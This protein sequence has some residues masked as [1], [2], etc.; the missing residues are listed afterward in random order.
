MKHHLLLAASMAIVLI[1]APGESALGQSGAKVP[2]PDPAE[3]WDAVVRDHVRPGRIDGFD[4]NV[5]DYAAI[6]SDARWPGVLRAFA[7]AAEPRPTKERMAFWINAYNVM[8]IHVV[9]ENYPV[10]SIRDVGSWLRPVWKRDAGVVAGQMRTLDEIE[11][12][13]LRSMGD[14]R[15]HAAV[16]C[17]SV[18]CPPLR[19][20]AYTGEDLD[21]Q[22]DHQMRR[23]L[24][25]PEIGLTIEREG[26]Q[27]RVSSIFKWFSEDFEAEA[28]SVRAYIEPYLTEQ[29]RALLRPDARIRYLDYD[30]TL[31]DA[32]RSTG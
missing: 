22:L 9:L 1:L 15:I 19:A 29:Q 8:A 31:N 14:A 13:I 10:D 6:A 7:D 27:A 2:S 5:V 4:I 11:H 26:Q 21:E 16:V 12:E 30:W 24:A 23:W 25:N 32:K 18:S 3:L 28:G 17:A 20:E